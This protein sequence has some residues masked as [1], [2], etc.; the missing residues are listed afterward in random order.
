MNQSE[1]RLETNIFHQIRSYFGCLLRNISV[2]N[3]FHT[4][5]WSF[6]HTFTKN[7]KSYSGWGKCFDE[8]LSI[9][10]VISM[11]DLGTHHGCVVL[12]LNFMCKGAC[13]L[14]LKDERK[15]YLGVIKAFSNITCDHYCCPPHPPRNF[16]GQAV[17][18]AG[19][20]QQRELRYDW[21]Q[22]TLYAC[23]L[24]HVS[25]DMLQ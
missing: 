2:L 11:N 14:P 12:L 4:A 18:C 19:I 3:T 10:L 17:H 21:E 5:V 22:A 23:V 24:S 20:L 13:L 6:S 1:S 9:L 25:A 7:C 15:G 8:Q 16:P